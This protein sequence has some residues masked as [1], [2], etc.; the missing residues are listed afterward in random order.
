M[1]A[2]AISALKKMK[3]FTEEGVESGTEG[4]LFGEL[5]IREPEGFRN[6]SL[7]ALLLEQPWDDPLITQPLQRHLYSG[8]HMV[9]CRNQE[10]ELSVVSLN[11]TN[12]YYCT[13]TNIFE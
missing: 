10:D 9:F 8:E 13:E 11:F 1:N 3:D 5:V 7:L 2:N 6:H 12:N 4:G